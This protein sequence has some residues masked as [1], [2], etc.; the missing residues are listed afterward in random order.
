MTGEYGIHVDVRYQVRDQNAAAIPSA[1]MIPQENINGGGWANIGPSP[2]FMT[3]EFT[4]ADGTYHDGPVGICSA[5]AFSTTLTQAVR[6]AVTGSFYNVR[7]NPFT[8]SGSSPGHGSISNGS[9]IS[10]TR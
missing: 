6:I 1:V 9:D 4:D 2:G 5:V 7:T 10:K 3:T 8:I